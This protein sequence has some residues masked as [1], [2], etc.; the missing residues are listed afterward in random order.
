MNFLGERE[1]E[2]ATVS[3]LMTAPYTRIMVMHLTLIFGGWIVL[4]I[5]MRTGA[6][7]VLLIVKTAF[8]LH[9]HRREHAASYQRKPNTIGNTT[10]TSA[11][12]IAY[13]G[14]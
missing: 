12:H 9:A 4:L 1:Y 11:A 3:G 10:T 13:T 5:G 8:D 14:R 7:V 6:L 2:G